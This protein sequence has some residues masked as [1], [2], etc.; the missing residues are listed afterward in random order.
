MFE[1][2]TNLTLTNRTFC[3]WRV[4]RR[5]RHNSPSSGPVRRRYAGDGPSPPRSHLWRAI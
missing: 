3:Q 1:N 4:G 2:I 5:V